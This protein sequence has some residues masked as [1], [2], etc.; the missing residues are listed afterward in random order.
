M[1]NVIYNLFITPIKYIIELVYSVMLRALN[2]KGL[3]IICV[4]LAVQIL[5]FPL[6]KKADSI[7]EK[8]R[9]QQRALEKWTSHIKKTFKGNERFMM[10]SAFYKEQHYKPIYALKGSISLLLQV[11]FFI[12]AYSF[13]SN[14][15]SLD[16][17]SFLFITNLAEPDRLITI[18]SFAINILPILMTLINILSG[19]IYTKGFPL[20]EKIQL[21][22]M[23]ALFLV[24]LYNSPSG[25]VLYWTINN[26]FSLVKNIVTKYVK[27]PLKLAGICSACVGIFLFTHSIRVIVRDAT[28]SEHWKLF[29]FALIVLPA[30]FI[31]LACLRFRKKHPSPPSDRVQTYDGRQGTVLFLLGGVFLSLFIGAYIPLTVISSSP[32]EFIAE[33]YGPT[34]LI[35]EVLSVSFGFFIV[36][37]GVFF[38]LSEKKVKRIITLVYFILSLTFVADFLLF[39][40]KFG[41]LSMFM[42]FDDVMTF[43]FT[44]MVLGIIPA[45]IAT[46]V[47]VFLI[48][49]KPVIIKYLY[50]I[51]ISAVVVLSVV[52][53]V[54]TRNEI[55]NAS[56]ST[57]G[58]NQD[59]KI[60]RLSKTG[61]NV[62]LIMLDRA[63][64]YLIPYIFNEKPEL[65]DTYSDFIYYPNTISFGKVTIFGAPSLFGGYEYTPAAMNERSDMKIS[66]KHNE[67]LSV[68]PVLFAENGYDVTV[69]DPPL[70][71]F[72]WIPDLSVYDEYD[73]IRAYNLY[74]TYAG[75]ITSDYDYLEGLEAFNSRCLFFYGLMRSIPVP[76]QKILYDDGKY[77]NTSI[78][79]S[80][81]FLGYY[82]ELYMLPEIT[83][84]EESGDNFLMLQNALPHQ[85]ILLSL[86]D[87]EPFGK[88][89]A[90]YDSPYRLDAEGN[91]LDLSDEKKLSHY[92]VNMASILLVANW[93]NY[94]KENGVY[95]N[96]R[97]IIAADHGYHMEH[98]GYIE[99]ENTGRFDLEN[100]N[101]LLLY[102]DFDNDGKAS[103]MVTDN[104]F[105]TEA[106]CPTFAVEGV[107]ENPVNPFTGNLINSK[108]KEAHPQIITT[109]WLFEPDEHPGNEYNTSD[110]F[111]CSVHDNIFDRSNWELV[112]FDSIGE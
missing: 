55:S 92:H 41:T 97:I 14:L 50:I 49:K 12:A 51:L 40:R 110:G 79:F 8:E 62:V 23:A 36:L 95:N 106:D 10:L 71:G 73:G 54:N 57:D 20:R 112:N 25:L 109:S 108:E 27:N 86:P 77:W 99:F 58:I 9:E 21:Y 34:E 15:R 111:W 88:T 16:G 90:A 107:I 26:L 69:C 60:I 83:S 37:A 78:V 56:L 63:V 100:F 47:S 7:Q 44:E 3:A 72:Q 61:K 94:L 24:L 33:S 101:P 29:V 68:L 4:S 35:T 64:S 70:V 38:F 75:N 11:P 80:T 59:D 85:P 30:S 89:S 66:D 2:I 22:A 98:V 18:G 81:T 19:F 45:V 93:L 5:V 105:M 39:D 17:S 74:N 84:I 103:P 87:Y 32:L 53:G 31:P 82:G 1:L 102:K 67:A 13:L 43:R 52:N 28:I 96:T 65:Y 6:Y 48:R 46:V 76:M 104:S 42:V 91:Q